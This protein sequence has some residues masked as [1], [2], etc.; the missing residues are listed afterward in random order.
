MTLKD[1]QEGIEHI[2]NA[3]ETG[4]KKWTRSCSL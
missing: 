4:M 2:V 3:I 1:A